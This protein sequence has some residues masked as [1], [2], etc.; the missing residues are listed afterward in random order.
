MKKNQKIY[1]Y[2]FLI[3]LGLTLLTALSVTS[4]VRRAAE[5]VLEF[6]ADQALI[7][8]LKPLRFIR[9]RVSPLPTAI[10]AAVV[11]LPVYRI[12][13]TKHTVSRIGW[14]I[15][16]AFLLLILWIISLFWV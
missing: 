12:F 9:F 6:A 4:F 10:G 11:S 5:A 14:I 16:I 1:L 2:S 13:K 8:T 15:L 7:D 3:A